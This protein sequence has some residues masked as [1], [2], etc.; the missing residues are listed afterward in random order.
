MDSSSVEEVEL[1]FM[2]KAEDPKKLSS[3]WIIFPSV[4]NLP[5]WSPHLPV[6]DVL[7][8]K[9]WQPRM[10]LLQLYAPIDHLRHC[11]HRTLYV[12]CCREPSWRDFNESCLVLGFCSWFA[13]FCRQIIP[14]ILL[15]LSVAMMGHSYLHMTYKSISLHSGTSRRLYTI[16]CNNKEC[17]PWIFTLP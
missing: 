5:G 17:D 3:R 11:Y 15:C 4:V 6:P 16:Q 12:F 2:E 1:G 8:C 9:V 10:F 14:G 7:V 13:N